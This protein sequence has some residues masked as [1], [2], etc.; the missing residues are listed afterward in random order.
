MMITSMST[1]MT[2]ELCQIILTTFLYFYLIIIYK[3]GNNIIMAKISKI[4][5]TTIKISAIISQESESTLKNE[6]EMTH[7]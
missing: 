6:K 3:P 2:G 1:G 7:E 5:L 4:L